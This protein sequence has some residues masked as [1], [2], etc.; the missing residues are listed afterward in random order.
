[1][2][3]FTSWLHN[4]N[5]NSAA[6][7][8]RS[9]IE[10]C[11]NVVVG[12]IKRFFSLSR[13]PWTT[14]WALYISWSVPLFLMARI[15]R[16]SRTFTSCGTS[17][18][19]MIWKTPRRISP[20]SSYRRALSNFGSLLLGSPGVKTSVRYMRM[21]VKEEDARSEKLK[22]R[23]LTNK[24]CGACLTDSTW[25]IKYWASLSGRCTHT[26]F[27]NVRVTV[28]GPFHMLCFSEWT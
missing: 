6:I 26:A 17:F 13:C 12:C 2:L 11:L 20:W 18:L 4:W 24:E 27:L 22:D 9:L 25:S 10:Q 1:M 14:R 7:A 21:G 15:I 16:V 5:P 28:N 23:W 3:F 19:R 8:V